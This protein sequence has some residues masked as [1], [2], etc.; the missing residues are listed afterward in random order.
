M[1]VLKVREWVCGESGGWC[2]SEW[3]CGELVEGG[4][5]RV[6]VEIVG[7][8]RNHSTVPADE[9]MCTRTVP[10]NQVYGSSPCDTTR[11]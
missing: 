4:V 9:S 5:W 1:G 2:V 3:V 7:R 6:S 8:R 10:Q 11:R